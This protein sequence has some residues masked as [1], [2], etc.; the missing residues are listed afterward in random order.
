LLLAHQSDADLVPGGTRPSALVHHGKR[1]M[2][3]VRRHSKLGDAHSLLPL[4]VGDTRSGA[5]V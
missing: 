1:Q 4:P 3:A 2:K 5:H